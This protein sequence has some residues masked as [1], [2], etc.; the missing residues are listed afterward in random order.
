[1]FVGELRAKQGRK[2]TIFSRPIAIGFS[3]AW[4]IQGLM[5][6]IVMPE[7]GIPRK[8]REELSREVKQEFTATHFHLGCGQR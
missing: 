5:L 4:A 7:S 6:E 8:V 2:K 3:L 1:L